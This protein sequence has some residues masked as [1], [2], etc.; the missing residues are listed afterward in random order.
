MP[1]LQVAPFLDW[2]LSSKASID[3]EKP[4][5]RNAAKERLAKP[6]F[7][8]SL[9]SVQLTALSGPLAPPCGQFK[10]PP[11]TPTITQGPCRIKPMAHLFWL[12]VFTVAKQM[13]V[14]CSKV[15]HGLLFRT[16]PSF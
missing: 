14:G 3:L 8:T 12:P 1:L 10:T 6:N 2:A 16:R 7:L 9:D 11:T 13:L 5:S 4:G 15:G